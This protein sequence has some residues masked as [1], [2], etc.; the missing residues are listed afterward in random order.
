LQIIDPRK[1]GARRKE[2][3]K[4]RKKERSQLDWLLLWP[5]GSYRGASW[6]A[7]S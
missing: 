4:E 6:P 5:A 3:K 1:K 7:G 2:R